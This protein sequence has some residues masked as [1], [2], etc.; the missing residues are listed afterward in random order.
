VIFLNKSEV[1]FNFIRPA[2]ATN[3]KAI[4]SKRL[5]LMS[6]K[7]RTPFYVPE[8]WNDPF[9]RCKNHW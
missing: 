2:I 5:R 1:L 8:H 6:C 9:N 4:A 3:H 7:I